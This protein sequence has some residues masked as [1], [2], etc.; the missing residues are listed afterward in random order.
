MV[1]EGPGLPG[2]ILNGLVKRLEQEGLEHISQI[3]GRAADDWAEG[4]F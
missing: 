4:Y 3:T 2:N 1:Y